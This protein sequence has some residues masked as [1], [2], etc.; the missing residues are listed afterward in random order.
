MSSLVIVGVQES[1]VG[2]YRCH[3][4]NSEGSSTSQP[5]LLQTASKLDNLHTYSTEFTDYE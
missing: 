2:E 1:N 5:A 3:A 4:A